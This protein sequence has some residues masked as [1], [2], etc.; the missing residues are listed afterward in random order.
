MRSTAIALPAGTAVT[1][2]AISELTLGTAL[3][4]SLPSA[5]PCVILLAAEGLP[6]AVT[7]HRQ[8]DGVSR[9]V[10]SAPLTRRK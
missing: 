2:H 3:I 5:A 9:M 8:F 10:A 6:D 7:L 1:Y 4:G